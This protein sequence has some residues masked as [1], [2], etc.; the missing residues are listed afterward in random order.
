MARSGWPTGTV[1][2]RWRTVRH[3]DMAWV[4]PRM[5]LRWTPSKASS[6]PPRHTFS[7]TCPARFYPDQGRFAVRDWGY[8]LRFARHPRTAGRLRSRLASRTVPGN[9]SPG[10]RFC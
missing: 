9:G 1:T 6:P 10:Q 8:V 5:W 3:F 7:T 4:V 2:L